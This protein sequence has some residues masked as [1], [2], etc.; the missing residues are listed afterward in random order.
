MSNDGE[1]IVC[2]RQT[3]RIVAILK[4]NVYRLE[5]QAGK[6]CKKRFWGIGMCKQFKK[7]IACILSI[8]IDKIG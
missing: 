4:K 8:H 3:I 6:P 7:R 1:N 2:A 5:S